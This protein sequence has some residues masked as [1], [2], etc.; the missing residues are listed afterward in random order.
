MVLVEHALE[1]EHHVVGVERAARLEVLGGVEFHIRAQVKDVALAVFADVPVGRQGRHG[2]GAA[3]LELHQAVEN[4]FGGR[5]EVGA[6]RVL[7]RVEAGGAAFGAEDQVAGGVGEAGAEDQAGG[8]HSL[9]LGFLTHANLVVVVL[10]AAYQVV[11]ACCVRSHLALRRREPQA[12]RR[13]RAW[14]RMPASRAGDGR[15]CEGILPRLPAEAEL[16]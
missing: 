10:R 7:A 9:E 8:E 3:A 14:G 13:S 2:A 1:G 16:K 5:V 4:G 11:E 12:A 15:R 6:G